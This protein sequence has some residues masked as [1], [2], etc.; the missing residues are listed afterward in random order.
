MDFHRL[1]ALITL[2][3]FIVNDANTKPIDKSVSYSGY[4][5][6]QSIAPI[7]HAIQEGAN[8]LIVDS[9]GGE[10]DAAIKLAHIIHANNVNITVDGVCMSACAFYLF[11]ASQTRTIK[12]NSLVTFHNN[13]YSAVHLLNV[14]TLFKDL[15]LDIKTTSEDAKALYNKLGISAEVFN[16]AQKVLGAVCFEADSFNAEENIG[17]LMGYEVWV[18]TK[19]YMMKN[20][21]DFQGYW[22]N[23][24]EEIATMMKNKFGSNTY[25]FYFGGEKALIRQYQLNGTLPLCKNTKE[26]P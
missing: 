1:T 2:S 5:N 9:I 10:E 25:I 13:S 17:V 11:P 19:Q 23:S 14:N 21:Y 22:P 15:K 16:D 12:P 18:P 6:E 24:P 4:I 20:G 26:R 7:I 8:E 3:L